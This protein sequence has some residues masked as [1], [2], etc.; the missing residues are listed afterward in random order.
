MGKLCPN[1]PPLHLPMLNLCVFFDVSPIFRRNSAC[2]VS[3]Y[4]KERHCDRV[5]LLLLSLHHPFRL[6]SNSPRYAYPFSTRHSR[7]LSSGCSSQR[8]RSQIGIT[9]LMYPAGWLIDRTVSLIF[10]YVPLSLFGCSRC[11]RDG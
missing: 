3:I 4:L 10:R 6:L 8:Y 9:N 1:F 7:R 11:H 5:S 2:V